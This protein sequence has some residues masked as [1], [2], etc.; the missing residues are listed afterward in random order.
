MK[1]FGM[2]DQATIIK[3]AREGS[4]GSEIKKKVNGN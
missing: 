1:F 4:F 2:S 3:S